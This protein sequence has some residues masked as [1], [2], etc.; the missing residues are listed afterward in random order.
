MRALP[1]VISYIVRYCVLFDSCQD[2][3]LD[4]LVFVTG[5]AILMFKC[6][7]NPVLRIA[8]LFLHKELMFS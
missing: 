1:V 5:V 8:L 3:V 6:Q 4:L 7:I 2:G